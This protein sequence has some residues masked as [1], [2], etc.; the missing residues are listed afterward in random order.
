MKKILLLDIDDTISVTSPWAIPG[1]ADQYESMLD[2]E[3]YYVPKYIKEWLKKFSKKENQEIYWCTDRRKT[4][5]DKLRK[6]L[7]FEVTGRLTFGDR[8]SKEYW[9]KAPQIVKLVKENPDCLFVLADNDAKRQAWP[10][11][12]D[13]LRI[14]LPDAAALTREDLEKIDNMKA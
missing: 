7:G 3:P 1:G 8:L 6:Q 5:S 11:M 2:Y 12:P 4:E 14:I 10:E 13:N 9:K